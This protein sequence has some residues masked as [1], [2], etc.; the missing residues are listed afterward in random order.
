MN[1]TTS[2][3]QIPTLHSAIFMENNN[4]KYRL[5]LSPSVNIQTGK[6][7]GSLFLTAELRGDQSLML[8]TSVDFELE[9]TWPLSETKITNAINKTALTIN[10]QW[11]DKSLFKRI[12]LQKTSLGI[13]SKRL[14]AELVNDPT[15]TGTERLMEENRNGPLKINRLGDNRFTGLA[16]SITETNEDNPN[17]SSHLFRM[18]IKLVKEWQDEFIL[19]VHATCMRSK[20]MRSGMTVFNNT[21]YVKGNIDDLIQKVNALV[22]ADIRYLELCVD[23]N[24]IVHNA[25]Q[26]RKLVTDYV[27]TI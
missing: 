14:A 12:K 16:L 8:N 25:E 1:T 4:N 5:T 27:E 23:K 19:T 13:L 20:T 24:I 6:L 9:L 22:K 10:D 26:L 17:K 15:V 21:R 11:D 2:E 3:I 7:C 18:D